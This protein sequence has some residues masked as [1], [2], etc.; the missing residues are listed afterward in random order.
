MPDTA[1]EDALRTR[2]ELSAEGFEFCC[3]DSDD[4]S[5][6]VAQE[7]IELFRASLGGWPGTEV[8]VSALD[9][10]RWKIGGANRSKVSFHPSS[11]RPRFRSSDAAGGVPVNEL[12][13]DTLARLRNEEIGFVFQSFNLLPRLDAL[14]NVEIPLVYGQLKPAERIER[15]RAAL[16][17][18]GLADRMDHRPNELSGGQCQRVAIARALVSEPSILLADEPTG[19][20]DSRTSEEIML[21]FDQLSAGGA[22][23]ILVTHESGLAA[24]AS[25]VVHISDGRVVSG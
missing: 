17:R 8:G 6:A 9:H 5:D 13:D 4:I 22:T 19:N 24:H 18:V 10:L 7:M 23:V 16:D 12:E 20:L 25:K 3:L 15:A 11:S 21:L 2:Q 14:G 1:Y